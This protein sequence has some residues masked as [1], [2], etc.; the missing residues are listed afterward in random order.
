MKRFINAAFW[1]GLF[2]ANAPSLLA[3]WQPYPTPGVPR[4]PNG[5]PNL[6]APAPRT[7]DGK[8]DLSGIWQIVRAPADQTSANFL[9]GDGTANAARPTAPP[10]KVTLDE[11]AP[12]SFRDSGSGFKDG[13]PLRPWAAKLVKGRM[14]DN[15]KD[16][17]DA[18]CLPMGIMQFHNHPQPRKIVQTPGLVIIIYEANFGLRQ[19][20]T[21]GRP[22]PSNVPEPWWFGYSV[23][24]WEGD[25]LVVETTGF[26]EDGWLDINGNPLTESAKVTERFRRMNYGNLEI[27]VTVDDSNAYTRPWTVKVKQRIMLDTELIEFICQD[28]DA[29]HYVGGK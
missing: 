9:G 24:R 15:S 11:I 1:I 22:L 7:P 19:I 25:T 13:L 28:K 8:P 27:E 17:P 14:A 5:Q 10:P 4:L 16:N 26:I 3:Q 6:E 23:G 29:P 20:F 21:D 18:H 12:A 2:A